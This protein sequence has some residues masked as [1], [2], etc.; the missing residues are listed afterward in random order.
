MSEGRLTQL[1][2]SA[3]NEIEKRVDL[4]R[5]SDGV[6]DGQGLPLPGSLADQFWNHD[7]PCLISAARVSAAHPEGASASRCVVGSPEGEV[8]ADAD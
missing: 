4:M 5:W 6:D 8:A 7:I 1:D 3:L 2:E